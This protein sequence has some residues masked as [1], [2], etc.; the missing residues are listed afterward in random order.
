MLRQPVKCATLPPVK[1]AH[2]RILTDGSKWRELSENRRRDPELDRFLDK[3]EDEARALKMTDP[4]IYQMQGRRL[5]H[6]SREVLRRV[7]LLSLA[8]HTTGD[9]HLA[10]RA[11]KEMLAAAA[12]AD[13][14]PSHFL[15]TAEM[16]TALAIGYD[17]LYD[18]LPAT[19][20]RT[21]REAI[22][23]KGLRPGL[24]TEKPQGF[25]KA[26][27][28][29]NQVCLGGMALGALAV[30][31]DEPELAQQ[32]IEMVPRYNPNGL[33]S[34]APDGVYP[35]GPMYW[36]YGTT[37]QVILL[38]ALETALGDDF[39]LSQSPGF[40]RTAEAYLQTI[41]PTGMCY[42]FFDGIERMG[43][44]P[45]LFWFAARLGR[46]ELLKFE[47]ESLRRFVDR[48]TG[49]GSRFLPL[50]ALWW[51]KPS[52]T[53]TVNLPLHWR[54]NGANPL[55]VFRT[56]WDDEKAM[57]LG[58]KGGAANLS[59]GHM[60]A[61]SF[62]F[63]WGGVRW[64]EDLGMQDYL[65]LESKGIGLW[66][67]KQEGQRWTVFRLNNFSH[68]TLTIGGALH[69]V[70]GRAEIVAF[71]DAAEQGM[72]VVDLSPVFDGQARR[73]QRGFLFRPNRH[74][75]IRDELEGLKA[76]ESVRW[77]MVT[78]SDV[79][80]EKNRALLRQ[81]GRLLQVHLLKPGDASF[82]LLD[83]AT[84]KNS[85]DAPNPGKK[86]LTVSVQSPANGSLDIVVI[87]Q[88]GDD[89]L[90]NEELAEQ[91]LARWK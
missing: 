81:D 2:P 44:E 82:E 79:K 22:V 53:T 16:T 65:S 6:V 55:A 91:P 76:G 74:V 54:G 12:F 56:S 72:A 75:L 30:W 27:N 38:A 87:L 71:S 89:E 86:M 46:P 47:A 50:I 48:K 33:K 77:A 63:E 34:Y 42:N 61:G 85:Y 3:L 29:W 43:L 57:Y 83:I 64:A 60:D 26:T 51:P 4:S 70:T 8:Y 13:W 14:N 52:A 37:Y 21:V 5:L 20:R 23:E 40:L 84:P 41:T 45:A 25:Y 69:R 17:W 49:G 36:G 19:T 11:A 24:S 78:G 62:I 7:M 28:N 31:E 15:D 80:F 10:E 18:W 73:V 90:S 35:E 32:I 68:N 9:A 59:H 67:F 1:T 58:L 88:P 66:D 39:G